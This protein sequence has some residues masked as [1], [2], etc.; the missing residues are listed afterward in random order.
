[1]ENQRQ[2]VIIDLTDD[3]DKYIARLV[4]EIVNSKKYHKDFDMILTCLVKSCETNPETLSHIEKL[5]KHENKMKLKKYQQTKNNLLVSCSINPEM[6][7]VV[8]L[9]L[10]YG[11]AIDHQNAVGN[12][13]LMCA[14]LNPGNGDVVK[15]LV[16]KGADPFVS[17]IM[18][19]NAL[20]YSIIGNDMT[21]LE[22]VFDYSIKSGLTSRVDSSSL[23]RFVM[24]RIHELES[25]SLEILYK[26]VNFS[27][28]EDSSLLLLAVEMN[29]I[30]VVQLY[31]D[32]GM[33]IK[34]TDRQENTMVHIIA[35]LKNNIGLPI[36]S[37]LMN[38]DKT[39]HSVKSLAKKHN[40]VGMDALAIALL[41][42]NYLIAEKLISI[43]MSLNIFDPNG[44]PII[45]H[46]VDKMSSNIVNVT[47]NLTI[48]LLLKHKY[49]INTKDIDGNT[50][51]HR[52]VNN[53]K[54]KAIIFLYLLRNGADPQLLNNDGYS[55]LQLANTSAV[56]SECTSEKIKLVLSM[57]D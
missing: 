45:S 51:L 44:I 36:L 39:K 47:N 14:C 12:T 50:V 38:H 52:F 11:A 31:L 46:I 9:L 37:L 41:S 26:I 54:C 55:V 43:G 42:E 8:G 10:K 18:E 23:C 30:S 32:I 29:Y 25:S 3:S 40:N 13:A 48:S 4:D 56:I 15:L 49:D 34:A 57:F 20:H 33:S 21:S 6:V 16:R 22:F 2:P 35:S 7:K 17:N 19:H 28:P 53:D 1:M 24:E 5:L 27:K